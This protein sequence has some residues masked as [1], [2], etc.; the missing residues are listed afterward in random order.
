MP[1]KDKPR[2]INLS[3]LHNNYYLPKRKKMIRRLLNTNNIGV[4]RA[5]KTILKQCKHIFL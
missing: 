4:G 3:L 5:I 1:Q 2:I